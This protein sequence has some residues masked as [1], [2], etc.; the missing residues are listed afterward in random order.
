MKNKLAGLAKGR[1]TQQYSRGT[2]TGVKKAAIDAQANRTI[3]H[4]FHS[5]KGTARTKR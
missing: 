2:M 4:S 5:Y 1:A 3:G